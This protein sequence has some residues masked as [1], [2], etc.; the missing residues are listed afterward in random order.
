[1]PRAG[2]PFEIQRPWLLVIALYVGLIFFASSRPYL[3]APGP[4]FQ[5]KDKLA[6]ALEYGVLGWLMAR[7]ARP[8][9]R[10]HPVVEVLWFVALGAGIAGLD[11]LF[12]GTIPGRMKD[13]TDWMA[14]VTGL[15]VGAMLASTHARRKRKPA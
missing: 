14:D 8:A 6:H 5:M 7:A 2:L 3:H 9:A 10:V 12:Q 4:E 1:M 13:V 11:E 15:L